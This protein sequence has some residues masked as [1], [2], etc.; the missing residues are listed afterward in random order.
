MKNIKFEGNRVIIPSPGRP[1]KITG[2]RFG[3]V[4]DANRW[5]TPFQAWCEITKAWCKPFEGSIYTEAGKVIEDKQLTWFS[6][7][8]PIVRPEDV[9]GE[10]FFDTTFGDF[11]PDTKIF[12]GM[13][14]S[15]V[16]FEDDVQGVIECKT[17]KRAEDWKDDIPEYYAL[18]AALYAYLLNVDDVYMIVTFLEDK[19]YQHPEKFECNTDN[20]TY[21][22]FKV[23]ERYPEFQ[24][25]VNY[26]EDFWHNSV[27]AGISPEFDEKEDK[28]YLDALRTHV[29]EKSDDIEGMIAEA[30][31]LYAKIEEV[32]AS[33]SAEEKRLKEIEGLLKQYAIEHEEADQNKAVFSGKTMTWTI[34]K[35]M[36]S[37]IDKERMKNDGVYDKYLVNS[38]SY[39]IRKSVNKGE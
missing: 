4:L 11:F 27:L 29:I 25:Y 23:S 7:L 8:L 31:A 38:E 15:L 26:C 34:T 5:Q 17:T 18:Q 22:H 28:E 39:T 33:V 21:V 16:G 19:D 35:S 20:T 2:T 24:K 13:W 36:K 12:G 1:K 6:R 9:Y 3:A 30:E 37:E 10:D 32:K 14:D